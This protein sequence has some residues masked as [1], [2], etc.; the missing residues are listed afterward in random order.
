MRNHRRS[1][2]LVHVSTHSR[3]EAAASKV[4]VNGKLYWVSTLSR[5]EAAATAPIGLTSNLVLFQHSAARRWLQNKCKISEGK[6]EVSTLSRAEAAAWYD[7]RGEKTFSCFNT[8]P[9]GGGCVN[10]VITNRPLNFVSTLS[11]AEA[12]AYNRLSTCLQFFLFQHS[13]ARRRLLAALKVGVRYQCCFNTQP[14][15]GGCVASV[16]RA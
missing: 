8:Q 1:A 16:D 5:A 13:A 14:R 9:R 10:S 2:F 12:A 4:E 3:A 7:S 11:R 6:T 15:G